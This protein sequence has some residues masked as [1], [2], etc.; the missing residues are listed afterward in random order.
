[1]SS[2]GLNP[3]ELPADEISV[4]QK[5]DSTMPCDKGLV[6]SKCKK[7][8][9]CYCLLEIVN[10]DFLLITRLTERI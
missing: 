3:K 8:V 5:L 4:R 6:V 2:Y 7:F 9:F 1:M 10:N